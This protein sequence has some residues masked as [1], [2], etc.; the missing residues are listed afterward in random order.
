NVTAVTDFISFSFNSC[1]IGP[2]AS[3]GKHGTEIPQICLRDFSCALDG[4]R[5]HNLGGFPNTSERLGRDSEGNDLPAESLEGVL[6]AGGKRPPTG[7][8]MTIRSPWPVMT[9]TILVEA[10]TR[11]TAV[12]KIM[13]YSKSNL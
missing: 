13:G 9:K 12:Q 6:K 5:N 11:K 3:G 2:L 4:S 10:V 8:L 7:A 1:Q